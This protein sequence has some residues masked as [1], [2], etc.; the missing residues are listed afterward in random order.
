MV[1]DK[2]VKTVAELRYELYKHE[3]KEKIEVT[4]IRDGKISNTNVTL[5][6]K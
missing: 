6:E 2:E 4:Y 1:N 3:T 5:G